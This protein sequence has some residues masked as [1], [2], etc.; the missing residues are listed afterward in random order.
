VLVSI[1]VFRSSW[2]RTWR[3][4]VLQE[5]HSLSGPRP[6]EST[7][8]VQV[9]LGPCT[10]SLSRGQVL[11]PGGSTCD[12]SHSPAAA[13]EPQGVTVK[14]RS[15][16][17]AE[18]QDS[19]LSASPPRVKK[20][21]DADRIGHSLTPTSEERRYPARKRQPPRNMDPAYNP[22]SRRKPNPKTRPP[23]TLRFADTAG[24]QPQAT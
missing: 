16:M 14:R 7:S 17:P 18:A 20:R 15:E 19:S 1:W 13:G 6:G 4:A 3:G 21:G 10:Q 11:G 24:G 5:Q 23:A 12:E 8:W 2:N 9:P 22:R